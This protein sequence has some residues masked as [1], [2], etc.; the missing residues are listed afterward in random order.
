MRLVLDNNAILKGSGRIPTSDIAAVIAAPTITD[1]SASTYKDI[2]GSTADSNGV[3]VDESGVNVMVSSDT[4]DA[5][6]HSFTMTAFDLTTLSA[7][8]DQKPISSRP[9]GVF[10]KPDGT[11][12]FATSFSSSIGI[13]EYTL[14]VP[15]DITSAGSLTL[16]STAGDGATI[17]FGLHFSPDGL[18]AYCSDNGGNVYQWS[19]ASPW[20]VSSPTFIGSFDFTSEI[21][22]TKAQDITLSQDGTKMYLPDLNVGVDSEIFQYTLN[23]PFTVSTAVYDSVVLTLTGRIGATGLHLMSTQDRFYVAYNG[24]AGGSDPE[25][26]EEFTI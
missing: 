25:A 20:D 22:A 21:G 3:W 12:L 13:H 1:F 11:K 2:S 10:L 19:L 18:N 4:P 23:T 5:D 26:I 24:D 15:Y 14:S 17:P 16:L 6:I 8:V 9:I 7:L